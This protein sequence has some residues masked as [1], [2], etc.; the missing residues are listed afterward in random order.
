MA[1]TGIR[2]GKVS[3]VNYQTGMMKVVYMDKG[4]A[5]TADMPCANYNDEYSMPKVGSSVLVA[6]LTNGSSR[7]VVIGTMWNRK[8]TPPEA[9]KELYRKDL[10]KTP[11]AA[12]VRYS[13]QSGEYLV[14]VPEAHISGVRKAMLGA[15]QTS[16]EAS[17]SIHMESP[18]MTQDIPSV[19]L[20]G[21]EDELI[22]LEC[23][24]DIVFQMLEKEL[25]GEIK[26][27]LIEI[28]ET[29]EIRAGEKL[30]LISEQDVELEDST[31]KTTLTKMLERLERLDGDASAR[32]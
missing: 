2:T 29:G 14:R 30:S 24:A 27:I 11:G 13:D 9:G 20:K 12:M 4:K 18:S 10:S 1:D 3:A 8:N 28:A 19:I 23:A 7:G 5:V 15:P 6:H 22:T 21:G 25:K 26:K 31:F 17:R 16:L 32:K